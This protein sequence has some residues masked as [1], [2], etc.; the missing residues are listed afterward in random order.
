MNLS[1]NGENRSLPADAAEADMP[2]LWALRDLLGLTGTK[3]G[4]GV[5]A[6]GACTVHVDGVA[7]R[8]C[9]TPLAAVAGKAI[10]TIEAL[11]G[12]GEPHALQ[13]AWIAHQVPQCG[14]CQ[15]G[16]LMAAA[17]LL[18]KNP[19]PSDADIDAAIT[20]L[21]RCGTYP[22]IRAAIRDAALALRSTPRR[23]AIAP[24]AVRP[25]P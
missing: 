1:V 2:L 10:R 19:N 5:A 22:R 14:Y 20:N 24:A 11:G 12:P 9:V 8:S 21:C 23:P 25:R 13:K 15:S 17:A 4:C 3:F 18:A 16:M 7:T 6:C